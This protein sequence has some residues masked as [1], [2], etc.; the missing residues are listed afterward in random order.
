M[1][2]TTSLH[3]LFDYYFIIPNLEKHI[4]DNIARMGSAS[5]IETNYAEKPK[6]EHAKEGDNVPDIQLTFRII[7]TSAPAVN[8]KGQLNFVWKDIMTSELFKGKR[9]VVFGVPGGK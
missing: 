5:S 9:V 4:T 6:H 2:Y 3:F 8:E 1:V 7:D